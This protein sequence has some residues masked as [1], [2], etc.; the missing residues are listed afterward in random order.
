MQL[1][2]FNRRLQD[3]HLDDE[4]KFLLAH[5]YDIQMEMV[6]TLDASL[7]VLN[8]LADTMN[9]LSILHESTQERV[10]ALTRERHAEVKSV[11]DEDF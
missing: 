1:M 8:A 6:K 11:R 9:G 10:K 4:T 7:T 5:I 2:E 3:C